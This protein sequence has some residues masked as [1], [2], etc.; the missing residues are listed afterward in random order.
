MSYDALNLCKKLGEGYYEVEPEVLFPAT[1]A[2][3]RECA[4][5]AA[6]VEIVTPSWEGRPD[7]EPVADKFLRQAESFK[8]EAYEAALKSY[9]KENPDAVRGEILGLA[10]SWFKRAL[11]LAV[12]SGV[13]I[14][15]AKNLDWRR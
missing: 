3:M 1:I 15:I 11:A 12:G 6:P 14:H 10:E 9:N 7:R 5:G 4:A 8:A 2:R 13:R